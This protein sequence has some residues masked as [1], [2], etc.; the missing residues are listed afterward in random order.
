MVPV[1]ALLDTHMGTVYRLSPDTVTKLVKCN[2]HNRDYNHPWDYTD[3]FNRREFLTA[4]DGRD[5]DT[6][7][8]SVIT[9]M[10]ELI[11]SSIV[12]KEIESL[13]TVKYGKISVKI[14]SYP[15]L[16]KLEA[17]N[18]L[19]SILS[20]LLDKKAS[21]EIISVPFNK[22]SPSYIKREAINTFV[23]LDINEWLNDHYLELVKTP[24]PDVECIAPMLAEDYRNRLLNAMRAGKINEDI[25]NAVDPF[26]AVEIGLSYLI[27]LS[28][29]PVEI[30]S[31]PVLRK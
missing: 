5:I 27:R 19:S 14:N 15:Y 18:E 23:I 22:V 4:W 24:I 17:M 9:K 20:E 25:A 28:F 2:Y 10:P 1:D 30:F 6:L 16:L 29:L 21:I 8:V 3:A 11:K 31:F 12:K 26:K 13:T 7:K